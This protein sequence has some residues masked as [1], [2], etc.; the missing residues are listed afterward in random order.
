MEKQKAISA[1]ERIM[2][3][4]ELSKEEQT[5]KYPFEVIFTDGS[6]A[7]TPQ[8][9]KTPWGV[10]FHCQAIRLKSASQSMTWEEAIAYCK[11]ITLS[12]KICNAGSEQYWKQILSQE[13]KLNAFI[14][15]L[16]G[17]KLKGHIW[18]AKEEDRCWACY[19]TFPPKRQSLTAY[20]KTLKLDVRPILPL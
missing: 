15:Q 16:G 20:F 17:D 12:G 19:A 8:K 2:K 11:D 14:E 10:I 4:N 6:R 5:D 7:W 3:E 9:D 18:T 13:T 1:N